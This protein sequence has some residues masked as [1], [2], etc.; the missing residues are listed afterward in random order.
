MPKP[1]ITTQPKGGDVA[2]GKT[3][4]LTVVAKDADRYEW[5]KGDSTTPIPSAVGAKYVPDALADG[6]KEATYKV[7]V[8]ST[9]GQT[10]TSEPA[11]IKL[12]TTPEADDKNDDPEREPLLVWDKTFAIAAAIT[13]GLLFLAV[14][15]PLWL[16]AKDVLTSDAVTGA[17][18]DAAAATDDDGI[19][20][21][22]PAMVAVQLM[23]V[24]VFIAL[25]GLYLSL[26][27]LRGRSRLPGE[28]AAL[29]KPA[30]RQTFALAT[31]DLVKIVPE[32]LNAFAKLRAPAALL[33]IAAVCFICATVI[34]ATALPEREESAKTPATTTTQ[35]PATGAAA[36]AVPSESATGAT[37]T[38]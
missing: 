13:V 10:A 9:D 33:A 11:I 17:A 8:Y 12:K 21:K 34:A 25:G 15:W 3:I 18:A 22:F 24:G 27:E 37:T 30:G 16:L 7:V 26:L 36:P 29:A 1:E 28:L 23:I 4:E 2:A 38:P 5:F 6:E 20:T 35:A 31:A 19:L 32:A 14:L